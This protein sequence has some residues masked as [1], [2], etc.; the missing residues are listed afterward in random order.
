MSTWRSVGGSGDPV[1]ASPGKQTYH[2]K[3]LYSRAG[4]GQWP[5]CGRHL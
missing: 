1:N 4:R 3:V 2:A 5:V